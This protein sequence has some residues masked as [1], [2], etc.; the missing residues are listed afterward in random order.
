MDI[1]RYKGTMIAPGETFDPAEIGIGKDEAKELV[2][3]GAAR[4][5]GIAAEPLRATL[6]SGH[7]VRTDKTGWYLRANRSVAIGE[8]G[9]Y[10]VLVVP[11]GLAE[12]F[13]GVRLSPSPAPLVVGQGG[14]DGETGPI[15]DF[16]DR[17]L[18]QG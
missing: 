18:A 1:D 6:L 16:L 9:G 3:S 8:D 7:R 5:R 15:G 13:R 12:R 14:R 10:Y 4:E 17:R 11:G 2:T